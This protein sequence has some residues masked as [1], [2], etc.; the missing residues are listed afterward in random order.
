MNEESSDR[1]ASL[2]GRR[3]R[4]PAFRNPLPS[5]DRYELLDLV[6]EGAMGTVYRA[7]D[8]RLRRTAAIKLLDRVDEAD[9]RRIQREAR[10]Q[11]RIDHEHVCRIFEVG[12]IE[13]RPYL[14]MQF[15]DGQPL[16]ALIV[17]LSLDDKIEVM[18]QAARAVQAAHAAGVVH[19]DLNPGNIMVER[20]PDGRLH[21]YVLDFGIACRAAARPRADT[22]DRLGTP[23]YTAP[24]QAAG[25]S[26]GVDPRVDV[27]GL[28]ATLY[29]VLAEQAPF[30]G[31]T[32]EETLR[33]CVE[34]EPLR[35]G[36]VVPG[37]PSDLE[38]IVSVAMAKRADH[39]YQ[40]PRALA[41]DL[42]R[43][44]RGEPI[45]ARPPSSFYLLT[46]WLRTRW[47]VTAALAIVLLSFGGA[48]GWVLRQRFLEHTR[49]ELV[50]RYQHEVEAMDSL[51]RRARMMP[52]HDTTS[53]EA[54]ARQRLIAIEATLLDEGVAARE[55]AYLAL[56]TGYLLL[57]DHDAAEFWLRAAIDSGADQPTA[58]PTLGVVLATRSLWSRMADLGISGRPIDGDALESGDQDEIDEAYRLLDQ[59]GTPGKD[60]DLFLRALALAIQGR[61][62]EAIAAARGSTARAPWLYEARRLEA[63]VHT[64]RAVRKIVAR[65]LDGAMSDLELAGVVYAD[66]LD[67]ARSDAWIMEDDSRRLLLMVRVQLDLGHGDP[68][69]LDLAIA[70]A[71]AAD[72]ARP[73]RAVPQAL[74]ASA[75][76][77]RAELARRTGADPS[78]ALTAAR[79]AADHAARLDPTGRLVQILLID[80]EES[81][82]RAGG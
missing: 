48:G 71:A 68:E 44:Q 30:F 33:K 70:R 17:E 39:R 82:G 34:E 52:L 26:G 36:R 7:V 5:W 14:A 9:A 51:L 21:T 57:R 63:G 74:T 20:R 62:E 73:G 43:W 64:I 58:R 15:I 56:G 77:L 37:T 8:R 49:T 47:G 46:T 31:S 80:V 76:L 1:T 35:L 28:G 18:R 2:H 81:H 41:D 24:E 23:A 60:R 6:G 40:S 25:R 53:A 27:Y 55:P 66:A 65:D 79:R 75:H 61:D 50:E 11:A 42:E 22:R 19:R 13:G 54:A 32:K 38:T 10:A 78:A 3:T 67:V 4:R 12:Q 29:A 16:Q 59:P 45:M 69:A 72:R